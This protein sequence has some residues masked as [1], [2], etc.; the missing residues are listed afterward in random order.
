MLVLLYGLGAAA[1]YGAADFV[2]GLMSR[3]VPS[4]T[5]VF[6]SQLLAVPLV[7]VALPLGGGEPTGEAIGWGAAAGVAGGFGV[8]FLYRGLS[9]GRMSVVAPITALAAAGL[10]VLYGIVEGERP[11]ALA[12]G[13]VVL[14]LVSIWLISM[15]SEAETAEVAT[16]SGVA[17][18]L[19]AG[20]G[21]GVFF[22]LLDRAPGGSGMWPL[23]GTRAGSL[24]FVGLLLLARRERLQGSKE[25]LPGT[26]AAGL[27]D[28]TANILYILA[29]RTGLLAIAAVLTS[30]YPAGT[31]LLARVFLREKLT[32][33]QI[34][35]LL[36]G[37]AG[38]VMIGLA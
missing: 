22:I 33:V 4:A 11:T 6:L 1:A 28:L 2:G 8:L 36:I 18:G 31:V 14:G 37:G 24:T 26:A 30:L 15:S 9:R 17:D 27:L 32:R 10:P 13:G 7:L 3:R 20:S 21:F 25:T 23:L 12:I 35:G 34:V 29:A 38:V 16:T 5:V 19:I